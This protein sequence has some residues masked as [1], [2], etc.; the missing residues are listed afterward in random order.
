MDVAENENVQGVLMGGFGA[1]NIP[2][3]LLPFIKKTRSYGKPVYVYTNCDTGAADMGI[4]AVGAAPLDAGANSAGD[5]TLQALGQKL[6][7]AI[8]RA[9][10]DGLESDEKLSFIDSIIKRSYNGDITITK[11]RR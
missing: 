1:G 6:M 9:N 5:M 8:G 7:Y 4:Y 2:D 11:K 3:R 10:D